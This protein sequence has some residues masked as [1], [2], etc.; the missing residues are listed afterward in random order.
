[1]GESIKTL[2]ET[3]TVPKD[4][5]L[6]FN[7]V[8]AVKTP[9]AKKLWDNGECDLPPEQLAYG[10]I[11]DVKSLLALESEKVILKLH[12]VERDMETTSDTVLKQKYAADV[13]Y[14]RY[15]LDKVKQLS[16]ATEAQPVNV[17]ATKLLYTIDMSADL[18]VPSRT[19]IYVN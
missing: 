14:L 7:I 10:T 13:E 5:A 4:E 17:P 19:S 2:M 12:K 1:M 9:I 11:G 15:K 8:G 18:T 6:F 16:A 3:N